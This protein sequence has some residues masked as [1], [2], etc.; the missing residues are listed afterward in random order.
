MYFGQY[1]PHLSADSFNTV[2]QICYNIPLIQ[3]TD[4]FVN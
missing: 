1:L 2:K 4:P 3:A